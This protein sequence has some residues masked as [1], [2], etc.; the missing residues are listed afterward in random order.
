MGLQRNYL[1]LDPFHRIST[2]SIGN[3]ERIYDVNLDPVK[4]DTG[5]PLI[6]CSDGAFSYLPSGEL[7]NR[8]SRLRDLQISVDLREAEIILDEQRK[9]INADFVVG[10]TYTGPYCRKFSDETVLAR[11]YAMRLG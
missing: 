3:F 11:G 10:V 4:G 7:D 9:D 1:D 5:L 8:P 6:L 2:L